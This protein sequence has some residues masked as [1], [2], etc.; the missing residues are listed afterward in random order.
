MGGSQ[1]TNIERGDKKGKK[2]G[3][4]LLKGRGVDTPIHTMT[5]SQ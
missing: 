4:V 2:E 3:V 5:N 1:K